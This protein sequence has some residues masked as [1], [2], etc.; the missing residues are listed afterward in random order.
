MSSYFFSPRKRMPTQDS[1]KVERNL[2]LVSGFDLNEFI[3][4]EDQKEANTW[5][6]HQ[7]HMI[8]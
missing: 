4:E 2:S 1:R 7:M 3:R 5:I 6:I 8:L